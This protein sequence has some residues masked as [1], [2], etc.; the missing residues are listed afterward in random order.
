MAYLYFSSLNTERKNNDGSIHAAVVNSA[1]VFS[2]QNEKSILEILKSQHLFSE[3][4]GENNYEQMASLKDHLLS[5]PRIN[6]LINQQC[7]YISLIPADKRKIDILYTTQLSPDAAIVQLQAALRTAGVLIEEQKNISKISLADSSVFY[8]G[9]KENV[10]L[11]SSSKEP[12]LEAMAA[13]FDKNNEFVNY[14]KSNTRISKNSLAELHIDFAALPKLLKS[15]LPGKLTGELSIL[16]N[17]NSFASLVYNYSKDKILLTGPTQNNDAHSYYQLFAGLIAQKITLTNILPANTANYS[18]FTMG[19]YGNWKPALDKW[20]VSQKTKEAVDDVIEK[21]NKKFRLDLNQ[22]F[23]KYFKDQIMSFQL[24][25]TERLGAINLVN[26]DKTD[27]LLLEL[28]TDYDDEIR[29]FREE[30]ILYA[31][32]GEPFKKFKRPY[33]T[34]IDNY[35]VFANNAST[36][37]SFLN[38][39]KNNRLLI[40]DTDYSSTMNLLPNTASI[41]FF[42]DLKHSKD[43]FRRNI[44]LPYYR[45]ITSKDGLIDY[46]SFT[47]QLSGD[48]GKFQTNVLINKKPEIKPDSLSMGVDS[49]SQIP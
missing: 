36:V 24:S 22:V 46:T 10:L 31:Y 25:T 41:S 20:F 16:D 12:V 34:I 32:F 19:N 2:F 9:M 48:N 6:S 28:S 33:Y 13:K 44:Y 27:Q 26:G 37:Q 14:I 15:V 29:I 47:Y 38:S 35:M 1:V 18:V 5:K 17:Q 11:L 8:L 4:I 40:D 30:N 3:L 45:H 49:L 43:I 21:H 7:I 39:Y 23:P 42:V